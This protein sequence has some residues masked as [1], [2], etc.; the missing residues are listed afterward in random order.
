M[1]YT[2]VT[3]THNNRALK[4]LKGPLLSIIIS[5]L[6]GVMKVHYYL[7]QAWELP[8]PWSPG[9]QD[10]GGGGGGWSHSPCA[11]C[12]LANRC[13][14]C[15]LFVLICMILSY[16]LVRQSVWWHKIRNSINL[17]YTV[18]NQK[19]KKKMR[20]CISISKKQKKEESNPRIPEI[21]Y[22]LPLQQLYVYIHRT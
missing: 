21:Y 4:E 1:Q 7:T 17:I 5:F 22:T 9:Q 10:Q 18:R 13:M 2:Q 15:V 19:K 14:A 11:V 16:S 20:P 12:R 3:H 8:C 6:R